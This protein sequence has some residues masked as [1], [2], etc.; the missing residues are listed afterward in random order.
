MRRDLGRA[1]ALLK[2]SDVDLFVVA[3]RMLAAGDETGAN[4]LMSIAHDL[5]DTEDNLTVDAI[6][7]N[8][9]QLMRVK[10]E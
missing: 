6:E 2:W 4:Y 10:P 8:A 5:Q 3:K 1:A 7:V 9:N